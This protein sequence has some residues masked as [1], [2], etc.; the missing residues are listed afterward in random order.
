MFA[1]VTSGQHRWLDWFGDK[2]YNA[3]T[4]T[5]HTFWAHGHADWTG[6][7]SKREKDE[8]RKEKK[9][10][11]FRLYTDNEHTVVTGGANGSGGE[12]VF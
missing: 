7:I 3:Q 6:M 1:F 10:R 4:A 12:A 11:W 2:E 8:A 5:W 9:R